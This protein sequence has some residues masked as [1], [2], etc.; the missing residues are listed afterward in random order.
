MWEM[1]FEWVW[2]CYIKWVKTF[3]INH[4]IK[5]DVVLAKKEINWKQMWLWLWLWNIVCIRIVII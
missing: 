4:G 1:N 5:E 2:L 3:R